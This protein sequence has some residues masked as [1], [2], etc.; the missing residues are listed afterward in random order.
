[1]FVRRLVRAE[2]SEVREV[3]FASF[4]RRRAFTLSSLKLGRGEG[5]EGGLGLGLVGSGR[6]AC[7]RACDDGVVFKKSLTCSRESFCL[8]KVK[9]WVKGKE[10]KGKEERERGGR[11][12]FIHSVLRCGGFI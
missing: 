7:V 4:S 6:I 1:M 3:I 8:H 10:R 11:V 5:G 12:K 2:I 9:E